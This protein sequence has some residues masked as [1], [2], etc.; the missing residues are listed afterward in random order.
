MLPGSAN[1]PSL[2][3]PWDT[4]TDDATHGQAVS[5]N[6]EGAG[7]DSST[8]GGRRLL[9]TVDQIG[10]DCRQKHNSYHHAY[11]GST[12]PGRPRNSKG[13]GLQRAT[14]GAQRRP[15]TALWDEEHCERAHPP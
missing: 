6:S 12:Y 13:A 9:P 5:R 11:S 15:P 14:R 10:G 8:P 1:L 3:R 7:L 2:S 4:E